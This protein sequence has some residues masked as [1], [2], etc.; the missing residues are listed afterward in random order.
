MFLIL[1]KTSKQSP[2]EIQSE[3]QYKYT[4]LITLKLS[5]HLR[6]RGKIK[7]RSAQGVRSL[8]AIITVLFYKRLKYYENEKKK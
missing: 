4:I 2:N 1:Y 5:I 7:E 6:K 3:T 8:Y